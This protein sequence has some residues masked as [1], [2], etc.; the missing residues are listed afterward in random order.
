MFF[1]LFKYFG[2][3]FSIKCYSFLLITLANI[4]LDFF[5]FF[6]TLGS[7]LSGLRSKALFASFFGQIFSET[8]QRVYI[9]NIERTR[10]RISPV[11]Y[12]LIFQNSSFNVLCLVH[13]RHLFKKILTI[14]SFSSVLR[15]SFTLV[16]TFSSFTSFKFLSFFAFFHS[17]LLSLYSL[18]PFSDLFPPSFLSSLPFLSPSSI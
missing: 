18:F 2:S 7:T 4:L 9:Q 13:T 15:Y 16:L 1:F 17:L 6:N 14:L 11:E 5:L 8:C 12:F 10:T 3:I